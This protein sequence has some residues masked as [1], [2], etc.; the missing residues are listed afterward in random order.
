MDASG[1]ESASDVAS[2]SCELLG[3]HLST[4]E[5][6]SEGEWKLLLLPP[7]F[8]DTTF[9]STH[10]YTYTVHITVFGFKRP[11]YPNLM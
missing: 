3:V 11:G 4:D 6:D 1:R 8:Y 5:E 2:D 7:L 10:N 9:L